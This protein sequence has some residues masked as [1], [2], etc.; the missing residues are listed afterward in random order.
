MTTPIEQTIAQ[1]ERWRESV[2]CEQD[3]HVLALTGTD[4]GLVQRAFLVARLAVLEKELTDVDEL[5]AGQRAI[6]HKAPFILPLRPS[7]LPV[8]KVQLRRPDARKRA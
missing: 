2:R 6:R 3:R 7:R 8:L 4:V 1:L 5:L